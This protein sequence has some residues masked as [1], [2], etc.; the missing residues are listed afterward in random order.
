MTMTKEQQIE[1]N[2]M[3]TELKKLLPN[4]EIRKQP[5]TALNDLLHLE[6]KFN[7][8]TEDVIN[9]TGTLNKSNISEKVIENWIFTFRIFK[10]HKGDLNTINNQPPTRDYLKEPENKKD[11]YKQKPNPSGLGFC[12]FFINKLYI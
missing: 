3:L 1:F 7:I 8:N 6:K 12:L 11:E 9:R 2:T 5:Q 4:A 10:T